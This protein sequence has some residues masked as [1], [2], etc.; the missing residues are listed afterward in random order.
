MNATVSFGD[1]PVGDD[2]PPVI[3]SD[4]GTFFGQNLDEAKFLMQVVRDSGSRFLK[5]E[6]LQNI[7]FC[8]DDDTPEK[9]VVDGSVIRE[10][11]RGL[12]ERKVLSLEQYESI[13]EHAHELDLL[14]VMSV[15]DVQG[16]DFAA[17]HGAVALKIA[18][19]N[20]VHAPL[21]AHVAQFGLPVI[22]DTGKSTLEEI[23]RAV[24]W[25]VD[26]GA[27]QLV[28]EHSPDAPP[29]DLTNHNLRMLLT[30]KEAFGFPVGLSDHHHGEEMMI[31]A[32][33]LG[34]AVLEKGLCVDGTPGD[35]DVFHAL[36]ASRL[37]PLT[38]MCTNVWTAMGRKMRY[39]PR[40]RE[41]PA[42]RMGLVLRRPVEPGEA[43]SSE[44]VTF[45]W[46]AHGIPIECWDL[47]RG[48]QFRTKLAPKDI[49]NWS[50][51][52]APEQRG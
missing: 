3:L 52:H 20:I 10:R 35:Q 33:A 43:V 5:G 46:P 15:Y 19:S 39:L 32:T 14:V 13:F 29:A 30:L 6:I 40:E 25:A 50:D 21:I 51:V 22:L 37:K 4:I 17:S 44:T 8:I 31:A 45:A 27:K 42:A 11:Y 49:L 1:V 36:P 38:E 48:W 26:A 41:K 47:V 18:S 7:D 24:Q 16:A 23:A 9:Y 28:I 12:I 2:H 34:A